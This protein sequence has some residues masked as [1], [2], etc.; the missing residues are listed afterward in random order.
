M[1]KQSNEPMD[2]LA[3]RVFAFCRRSRRR[4][5]K[6]MRLSQSTAMVPYVLSAIE[7]LRRGVTCNVSACG[8]S[9]V[10]FRSAL[11]ETQQAT[12]L[13]FAAHLF[14]GDEYLFFRWDR[15]IF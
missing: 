12:S 13:R 10:Y 5:S 7:F 8:I 11:A 14:C 9:N 6:S 1:S 15:D 3:R 4:R 2:D